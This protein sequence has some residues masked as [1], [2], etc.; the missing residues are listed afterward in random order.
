[1]PYL[2]LD[3]TYEPTDEERRAC[4]G[5]L[6]ERYVDEMSTT[7]GHVAVTIHELP[8]ASMALGRAVGEGPIVVLDADVRRGR[9][10]ERRRTF[11]LSVVEWLETHWGV[12]RPNAKVVY[13][14]HQGDQLMGAD[15]VGGEWSSEEG[16]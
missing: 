14:E 2:S 7:N 16:R 12:P 11:A 15:R 1:M 6:T 3:T 8:S 10:F 4:T 13:T 5:A 9:S